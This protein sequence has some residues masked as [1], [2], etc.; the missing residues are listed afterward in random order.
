MEA[1]TQ[2]G[3]CD[4]VVNPFEVIAAR[5]EL[6][7]APMS[8]NDGIRSFNDLYLAVTRAV[9]IEFANDRFEDPDFFS[10]LAPIFSNF[11]FEA[12]E[13]AAAK[14]AV[15]R[16][17]APLFERRFEPGITPL[18]FA[19]AGM[20][21]HI[22]HDL[23]IALVAVTK[24]LGYDLDLDSPHHRDHLR[25]N[26]TLARVM[27]EV[28][29]RFETGIVPPVE[30]ALGRLDALRSVERARDNAWT[31]AQTIVALDDEPFIVE[32]YL[33]AL[34]CT[35]GF[36]NRVLLVRTGHQR[37]RDNHRPPSR[38]RS[39]SRLPGH[40]LSL[41]HAHGVRRGKISRLL[42]CHRTRGEI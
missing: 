31:Q 20:N 16:V 25:V 15:S 13:A 5:M 24:E 35:V 41:D 12:V 30:K 2:K 39:A 19:I 14:R 18:Q 7:A 23:A 9:G 6:L 10:R 29:E 38:L 34:A 36:A 8:E 1:A 3:G 42:F 33:L 11:Y 28:K 27:D 40:K 32:Q 4:P 17:W 21:A 22:N 26:T 37:P